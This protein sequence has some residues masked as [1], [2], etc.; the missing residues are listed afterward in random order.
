MGCYSIDSVVPLRQSIDAFF[1]KIQLLSQIE[2][3]VPDAHPIWIAPAFTCNWLGH[4]SGSLAQLV[5]S[6][7]AWSPH[8]HL[9]LSSSSP[10]HAASALLLQLNFGV[11]ECDKPLMQWGLMPVQLPEW[12]AVSGNP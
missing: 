3:Y 10:H 5:N 1:L 2:A 8:H 9:P 4:T 6:G 7:R 11:V 12:H